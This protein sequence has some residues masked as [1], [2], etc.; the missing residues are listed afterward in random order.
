MNEITCRFLSHRKDTACP[1]TLAE[2]KTGFPVKSLWS[3][4]QNW[5]L[6]L[7]RFAAHFSNVDI[8]WFQP[9]ALSICYW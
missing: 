8:K 9:V 7:H 5:P 4:G 2:G 1:L 3:H 6:G